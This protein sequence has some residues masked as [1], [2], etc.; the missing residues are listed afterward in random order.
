MAEPVEFRSEWVVQ[1]KAMLDHDD[2]GN[3]EANG[4]AAAR[5]KEDAILRVPTPLL[6]TKPE[7]YN[8]QFLSIGPYHHS[9]LEKDIESS[10]A[11]HKI[12]TAE[13]Y[14]A[15]SAARLLRKRGKSIVDMME[16]MRAEIERFYH[17]PPSESRDAENSQNFAL[18]MAIDSSFLLHFLIFLSTNTC[19]EKKKIFRSTPR[20]TPREENEMIESAPSLMRLADNG[21]MIELG[22]LHE[23]IKCDILKLENQIPLAVL[24]GV[25]ENIGGRN[26][27][28]LLQKTTTELSPFSSH[29]C[30]DGD[31]AINDEKQHLLGYMH[32]FIAPNLQMESEDEKQKPRTALQSLQFI[33]HFPIIALAFFL[34]N[35]TFERRYEIALNAEK[36]AQGRIQFKPFRKWPNKIR[37]DEYSGTLYL[38][39]INIWETHMEVLLRNMVAME[40]NDPSRGNAVMRY[41][42]LM[43]C[44]IQTPQDVRVL[45]DCGVIRTNT[46]V[47]LIMNRRAVRTNMLTDECI[48]KMWNDLGQPFFT[49]HLG[50]NSA[51]IGGGLF[52]VLWKN[53]RKTKIKRMICGLFDYLSSWKFLLPTAGFLIFAMTV[54]QTYCNMYQVGHM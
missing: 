5:V 31:K 52:T 29:V 8:P 51:D 17:L 25:F 21:M 40:F 2:D 27:D 38:P 26:F 18:M 50:P 7:A 35:A 11:Q 53:D 32:T 34:P 13:M 22:P 28:Q 36:L 30:N 43:N 16:E 20:S 19:D 47:G 10:C 15:K 3:S 39:E 33:L 4:N 23:C 37:F 45:R 44:L 42:S 49:G 6:N 12:S 46:D 1:I 48:A 14:K 54:I 41:V 9:S 24:K